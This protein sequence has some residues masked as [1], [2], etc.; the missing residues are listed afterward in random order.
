MEA[1]DR[2]EYGELIKIKYTINIRYMVNRI[3]I[4]DD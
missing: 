4:A 2:S 1:P 3:L